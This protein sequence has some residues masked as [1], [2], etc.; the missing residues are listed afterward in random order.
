MPTTLRNTDILFNDGTTQ[1]S[2]LNT[3]SVLNATAGASVGAVGSY[4]FLSLT[5]FSGSTVNPGSTVS[6]S[7]LRYAGGVSA[8]QGGLAF[9]L[10]SGTAPSGTW[11][12]MGFIILASGG[13]YDFRQAGTVF[14]RIS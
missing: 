13:P 9:N 3:T 5:Q 10:I 11:R 8:G 4:A 7:S 12:C 1:S 6:G 2:A 14:L